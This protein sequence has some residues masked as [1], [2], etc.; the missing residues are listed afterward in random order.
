MT[1]SHEFDYF[2]PNNLHEVIEILSKY[3]DGA[4]ILAGGTDL[5]GLIRDDLLAPKVLVD[6][7]GIN[8]LKEIEFK[9]N[10]LLI[11]ALAT[12]NDLIDSEIM[13]EKFPL[14]VE[15]AKTVASTGIRNRATMVGNICSAVPCC[16]SGPVLL[17]YNADIVARG[18]KG[19]RHVAVK[20]WFLGP[21]ETVLNQDE[22]VIG[23]EVTLPKGS[24]AGA[25]AKL[26]RT[27]GE[28]LAQGSVAVLTL[29]GEVRVAFGAVAPTPVRAN[30]IET[31]LKKKRITDSDIEKARALVPEEILPITDVRA[32]KEYRMHM[33][34]V[35]FERAGKAALSRFAGKGPPYGTR[36]I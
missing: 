6:I 14:M 1:I 29:P 35:M 28:D 13:M 2:K 36:F 20:D 8:G 21:K 4:R 10:L 3:K 25:F 18:P 27:S 9:D 30:K 24:C 26:G 5:V 32:T 11:G 7:K 16:D 22:V 33:V 15:M 19:V 23:V 34:K 12:F 17:V 31:Y